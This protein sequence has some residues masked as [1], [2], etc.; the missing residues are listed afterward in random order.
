MRARRFQ[1]GPYVLD[2][3]R[4]VLLR[5]GAPVAIGNRGFALLRAL[6]E[7]DG[8]V[9]T[10]EGLLEAAWPGL[11]VEE[12]NLSVQVA[13]LRRL[14]GEAPGGGEWIVTVAR[15][16]YRFAA[17]VAALDDPADDP[18]GPASAGLAGRPSIAVL[19]FADLGSDPGTEYFADGIAEDLITA[20]SRFR[21]FSVVGRSASFAF[22]GS[23]NG[24]AEIG[25]R[26][27]VR[28]ALE[29]SVRRS[30]G[31]IR[32]SV[33]M[34]E[35]AS[36]NQLWADRH[37][38]AEG[39]ALDEMF[40]VQD[41]IALQ[42]AGAMEPELLRSES[43]LAARRRRS[44]SA[45][46]WD[47]V[48]QGAWLFHRVVRDDHLR[49]RELFRE[50]AR[51]DADLPEA[52]VWL[53]RVSAGIVAYGWSSDE[54]ADLREGVDAGLKAVQLDEL[55]PYAHYGLAIA[56]VYAD[57]FE[58]AIRAAGQAIELSPGFA[59]GHLVLGM[60]RLF[61]GDARGALAPL[62]KGLALNPHDPQNFV[63]N[64][65]LA[66]ALLFADEP[67]DALA[68]ATRALTIRPDWAPAAEAAAACH[69]ELGELQVARPFLGRVVANAPGDVMA[70]LRR[71]NPDWAERMRALTTR[72][73]L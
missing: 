68:A 56:S 21:W 38:I 60:A 31:R 50:A 66:W 22:R 36:G 9:L 20:L 70:P 47:R 19:P 4:S 49:A 45:T 71:Q 64:N 65:L 34:L 14:L 51:L 26:L 6:V 33:R 13:A 27:G 39:F 2:P 37:D 46:A 48:H 10:K 15:A 44:G 17:P 18:T 59:L 54:C 57:A 30:A 35:T 53:A 72:G 11:I 62:R 28:Y 55:N 52:R 16:G 12:G 43:A 58:P 3:G 61:A 32:I 23:T 40:A 73:G 63:W 1:I 29:G 69:A 8:R 67:R 7:A 5:D 25:R 42:V 24:P 41:R